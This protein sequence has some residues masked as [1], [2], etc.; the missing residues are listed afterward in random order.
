MD[1]VM[2][3]ADLEP[4]EWLVSQSS[5]V[6]QD[7]NYPNFSVGDRQRFAVEFH[8]DHLAP[9]ALGEMAAAPRGDAAY[10]ITA[11]VAFRAKDLVLLDFG[12]LAY[13]DHNEIIART[14]EWLTGQVRLAVDCYSYFEIHSKRRGVPSAI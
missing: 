2:R 8:V 13:S 1:A 7:G 3:P 6:I 4:D 5:W 11:Q 10:D 9:A 14:G 12:I